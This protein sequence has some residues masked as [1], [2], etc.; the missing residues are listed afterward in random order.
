MHVY[1]SILL[2]GG[3]GKTALAV[4]LAAALV[5]AGLRVL[6]IDL[7]PQANA[8][9][10]LGVDREHLTPDQSFLGVVSGR[11]LADS[12]RS[13]DDGVDLVPAHRLMASLPVH[14]AAA[15]GNGLF[16]LRKALASLPQ[17]R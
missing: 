11:S 3:T 16:V 14:L 4:N 6:L 17:G 12:I 10:W 1:S 5:Q 15:P 8:S 13:T 9:H 2:K 7:D